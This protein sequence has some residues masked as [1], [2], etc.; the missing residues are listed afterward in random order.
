MKGYTDPTLQLP[1][2]RKKTL[3]IDMDGVGL[4]L[5]GW[6]ISVATIMIGT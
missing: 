6:C 5:C 4:V 2:E 1:N 3:A